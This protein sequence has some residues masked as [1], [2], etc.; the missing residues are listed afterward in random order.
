MEPEL[1]R[2]IDDENRQLEAT[3]TK[4]NQQYIF[5]LKKSLKAANFGEEELIQALHEVLPVLVDGQKKGITARKIFGTV[6]ACADNIINKPQA[7]KEATPLLMWLDNALLLLGVLALMSGLVRMFSK[8]MAPYGLLTIL[9]MATTGGWLFNMMYKYS[10][11]YDRASVPK[12]ERPGFIK[13][14]LK[15]L[16]AMLFCL[17]AMTATVMLPPAINLILDPIL[18]IVIGGAAFAIRHYLKKKY[19]IVG[20]F[21]M[22]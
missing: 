8:N 5:D 9:V 17:F 16:P 12:S 15:I 19:G 21:S 1:L 6:S 3:L 11:R 10:F 7:A 13:K 22:Q 20:A 4:R 14:T 2:Q 18:L